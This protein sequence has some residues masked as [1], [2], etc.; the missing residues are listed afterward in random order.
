MKKLVF[1]IMAVSA[2]WSAYACDICGC[3]GGNFYM[4][5]LPNFK[6]R[7]LGIRYHYMQYHTQLT[8]DPTQFSHN[9]YNTIEV[10]GGLNIGKKW[11]VLAFIPYY[12][13]K[14]ADDD[15]ITHKNGLGDI[16]L[17]GNYQLMH[18][19]R[20][21]DKNKTIE[22]IVW[23]GGGVKLPAGTFKVDVKDS[24]TTIADINAQIGTGSTDFLLNVMHNIRINQFGVNTSVN[25]KIGTA[26]NSAYKFGNKFTANSIAYYHFRSSGIAI[27]PNAGIIYENTG[28]NLLNKQKVEFTG[29]YAMS[30]LAGVEL[31]FNK[32]AIGLNIQSPFSQNYAEGQTKLQLR[33]MMHVTFAL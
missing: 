19:R 31:T 14:Q 2:A 30:A 26:N 29:G 10:W 13:N 12:I 28:H 9:Y 1:I 4:G 21:N 11:Q 5:L 20:T 27:V 32:M 22:Q 6:S 25:Y 7:F 15:A 16:T 18:T 24:S 3:G 8:N 33:G 23:I 17:L